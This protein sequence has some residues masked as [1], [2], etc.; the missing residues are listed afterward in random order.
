MK[1]LVVFLAVSLGLSFGFGRS[2]CAAVPAAVG[3]SEASTVVKK[4]SSQ[5]K[6]AGKVSFFQRAKAFLTD[7]AEGVGRWAPFSLIVLAILTPPLAVGI[8][9]DWDPDKVLIAMLL[10]ALCYL[11]G[12]IY[13][14]I[15]AGK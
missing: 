1:G 13:A 2:V 14:I 10:T 6:G 4:A 7:L 5:K 9:S 11:P 12:V 3:L 8:A 15:Q